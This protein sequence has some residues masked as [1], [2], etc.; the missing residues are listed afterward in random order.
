[1]QATCILRGGLVVRGDHSEVGAALVIQSRRDRARSVRRGLAKLRDFKPVTWFF[2][3][4]FPFYFFSLFIVLLLLWRRLQMYTAI[5]L[6]RPLP[7]LRWHYH[8]T[9]VS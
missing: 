9:W 7:N 5:L 3:F 8:C 6:H 4:Y 1:M 2:S